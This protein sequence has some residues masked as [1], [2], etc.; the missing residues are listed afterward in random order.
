M[1]TRR[2]HA[3]SAEMVEEVWTMIETLGVFRDNWR[4]TA[5]ERGNLDMAISNLNIF[6]ESIN[7]RTKG[8]DL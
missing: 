1:T 6:V 4:L 7:D 2:T 5:K 8:G 3:T